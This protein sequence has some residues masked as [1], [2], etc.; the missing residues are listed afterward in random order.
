MS[1]GLNIRV[2][3]DFIGDPVRGALLDPIE[4]LVLIDKASN[5]L[6]LA[7]RPKHMDPPALPKLVGGTRFETGL[8]IRHRVTIEHAKFNSAHA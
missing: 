4:G 2:L 1:G 3:H 7:G 5:N 6:G 8:R